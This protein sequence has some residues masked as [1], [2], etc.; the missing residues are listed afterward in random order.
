MTP[1]HR[2]DR[3][4]PH[5]PAGKQHRRRSNGAIGRRA[6]SGEAVAPAPYLATLA[7][8]NDHGIITKR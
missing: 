4:G 3:K 7:G 1:Y 8:H 5:S 2:N 6:I